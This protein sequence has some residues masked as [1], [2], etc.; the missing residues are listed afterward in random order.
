V[1]PDEITREALGKHCQ[2][3]AVELKVNASWGYRI[4]A[5]P[6]HDPYTKFDALLAAAQKVNP[7][8]AELLISDAVAR[9]EARESGARLVKSG[10]DWNIALAEA[11][12][13]TQSALAE[14][15]T[16]GPETEMKITLA[17]R[18]L[19]QLLSQHKV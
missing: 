12:T 9:Y 4:C 3:I 1:Q 11:M 15:V 13:L 14:A 2:E 19:K 6:E 10:P 8:G 16:R 7:P 5:G 17:I 18:A